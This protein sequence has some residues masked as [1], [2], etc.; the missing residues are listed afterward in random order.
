[1]VWILNILLLYLDFRKHNLIFTEYKAYHEGFPLSLNPTK[2]SA[3]ITHRKNICRYIAVV[4]T[5]Q[6]G[7]PPQL[8]YIINNP[9]T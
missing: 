4:Y 7:S 2:Q 6:A 1:M 3:A 5:Q 8:Y 9:A